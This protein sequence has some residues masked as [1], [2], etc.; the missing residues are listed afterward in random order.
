M[1]FASQAIHVPHTPPL[2]F[3]GD[4]STIDVP[5]A[6]RTGG[7]TSDMIAKLDLQ[8]AALLNTLDAAGTLDR[9]LVFFTSDNGAL[10]PTIT[11]YGDSNHDSNGP[12]RGYKASVYEGGHRVP[13]IVRWGD[14]TARGSR[15]PPGSIAAQTIVNHDWVAT[16]Y[17]LTGQAMAPDQ[18]MDSASLLP[19]LLHGSKEPVHDVVLYQAGDARIGAIRR[20]DDVLVLDEHGQPAELYDLGDDPLQLNNR[21][22]ESAKAAGPRR[23]SS[24]SPAFRTSL[25]DLRFILHA[26]IPT[27]AA[28]TASRSMPM[29]RVSRYQHSR[30]SKLAS[31]MPASMCPADGVC[32]Y[33]SLMD[34]ARRSSMRL[35]SSPNNR[36]ARQR[37][38]SSE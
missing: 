30:R 10:L 16:I 23:K 28:V 11:D 1:Y 18:A 35:R 25:I 5:V 2:D 33:V 29:V 17:E 22:A 7:V 12:W 9:T 6:G 36:F 13:F 14:G 37:T 15:I 31:L 19:V 26:W 4:P 3:D 24:S 20:G 27:R 21:V 38:F 8:V 34:P 32:L